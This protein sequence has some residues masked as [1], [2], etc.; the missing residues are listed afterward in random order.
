MGENSAL[1]RFISTNFLR[2][3]LSEAFRHLSILLKV[4]Q[5]S[6][7]YAKSKNKI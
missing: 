3:F 2:C 4:F 5:L 7:L 6:N 1:V